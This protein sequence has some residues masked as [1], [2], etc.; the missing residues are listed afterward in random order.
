MKVTNSN[1]N[2]NQQT[3]APNT[4][5]KEAFLKILVTQMKYQ[6]PLAPTNDTEFIAQMAQFSN[7][8][9]T[10]NMNENIQ[11]MLYM[12]GTG[13]DSSNAFSMIGKNVEI[14]TSSGIIQGIVEKVTKKDGEFMVEVDSV[15]YPLNKV[16]TVALAKDSSNNGQNAVEGDENE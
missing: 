2:P 9:Q 11:W 3:I 16:N 10:V 7:L 1:Y 13:F 12:L 6:D 14:E 8:E 4:L 5:G 15:L